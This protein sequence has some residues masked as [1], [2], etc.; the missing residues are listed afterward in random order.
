[1]N[2]RRGGFNFC[3]ELWPTFKQPGLG[4]EILFD[5]FNDQLRVL[6]RVLQIREQKD[7]ALVKNGTLK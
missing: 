6:D 3:H 2:Y 7:V 4:L 5:A 1:M